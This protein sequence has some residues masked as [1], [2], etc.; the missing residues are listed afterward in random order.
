MVKSAECKTKLV[1]LRL[2]FGEEVDTFIAILLVG[3]L[4]HSGVKGL[5]NTLQ[6]LHLNQ[7]WV[8]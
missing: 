8:R 7:V 4:M 3:E 6:Q 1:F 5:T 2:H